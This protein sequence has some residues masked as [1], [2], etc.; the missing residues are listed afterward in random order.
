MRTLVVAALLAL[1]LALPASAQNPN[2]QQLLGGLLTG[3]QG[4]DQALRE[5]Y[6]R[7]YRHGREDE[8]R[9]LDQD[10]GRRYDEDRRDPR[11]QPYPPPP[12]DNYR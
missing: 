12:G 5:A 1:P 7:G 4:Q 8:A 10:R 3:N 2:L 6:E 9:R 11:A